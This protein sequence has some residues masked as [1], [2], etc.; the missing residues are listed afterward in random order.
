MKKLII[1]SIITLF[2]VEANS[3]SRRRI[4]QRLKKHRPEYVAPVIQ[5]GDTIIN[6][7]YYIDVANSGITQ[8]IV[9]DTIAYDNRSI[10]NAKISL[11]KSLGADTISFTGKLDAFVNVKA[12]HFG[13]YTHREAIQIPSNTHFKMHDSI[14][15]RVQPNNRISYAILSARAADNVKI[16]GGNLIG[17]KYEHTYATGTE[18]DT[19]EFGTGIYFVGVTNSEIDGVFVDDMT[20]DSFGVHSTRNRNPDGSEVEGESYSKNILIKN[21]EFRGARRNNLSFIE[22]E[23]LILENSIIADAG[24]GGDYDYTAPRS[25]RGVLPRCNI[26]LEATRSFDT[27][28]NMNLSQIVTD[29]IIRNNTFTNAWISDLNL[30]TCDSLQIYGNT[31][32]S[33]I[34][35]LNAQD[36]YIHDNTFTHDPTLTALAT[37]IYMKEFVRPETGVE[38]NLN[39]QIYNNTITGFESGIVVGGDNHDIYNNTI[40]N[41]TVNGIVLRKGKNIN[42]T[43]NTV[44]ANGITNKGIYVFPVLKDLENVTI[45]GGSYDGVTYGAD[46]FK[47][48]GKGATGFTIDG[49]TFLNTLYIRSSDSITVKNSIYPLPLVQSNNGVITLTNNNP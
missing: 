34:S 39:Y 45:S 5:V 28:G 10:M 8:G 1:I 14:T 26:D 36:V 16:S 7:I 20:G 46:I 23:K 12:W 4:I 48:N 27:L 32:T 11:A 42:W 43:N 30:Y 35:N 15:F 31:F 3:Q 21:V 24:E 38:E 2:F 22:V 49:T 6:G 37:A 17:D 19:H 13:N 40:T 33:G 29:V 47:V 9:T 41:A 25:W 44:I 18:Q